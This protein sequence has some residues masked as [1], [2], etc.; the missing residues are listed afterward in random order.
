MVMRPITQLAQQ[1]NLMPDTST[2]AREVT[3]DN[4]QGTVA[5][6]LSCAVILAIAVFVLVTGGGL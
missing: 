1:S 4:K 2:K 6:L 5:G 3:M